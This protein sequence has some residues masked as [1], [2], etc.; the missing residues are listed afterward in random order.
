MQTGW[1]L[2]TFQ[3]VTQPSFSG[4]FETAVATYQ[5][6]LQNSQKDLNLQ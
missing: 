1:W 6:M 2:M 5:P 3:T 4:F